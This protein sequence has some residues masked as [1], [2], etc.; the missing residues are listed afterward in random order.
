MQIHA[1]EMLEIAYVFECWFLEENFTIS[2]FHAIVKFLN[3]LLLEALTVGALSDHYSTFVCDKSVE[4][5]PTTCYKFL[6]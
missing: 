6:T 5:I 2:S 4:L 3:V 1:K